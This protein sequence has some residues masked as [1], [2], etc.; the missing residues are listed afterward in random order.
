[1]VLSK[2][3]VDW[4]NTE[5][6]D[7]ETV[8]LN[9]TLL[10]IFNADRIPPHLGLSSN[11]AY[12]SLKVNGKDESVPVDRIVDLIERKGISTLI[13]ELAPIEEEYVGEV[14]AKYEK[15]RSGEV[16]CLDPIKDLFKI[17]G[18]T[19]HDII[20]ILMEDDK[21]IR[22]AGVNLS[23]AYNGIPYYTLEDIYDY[24]NA[25]ESVQG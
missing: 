7:K 17:E 8:S 11:G 5:I 14:F 22:V 23:D 4:E 9:G 10:W 15:A 21:V 19:V 24:L 3:E 6:L 20:A 18:K 1:M 16:T 12:Y 13:F 2:F 25:L